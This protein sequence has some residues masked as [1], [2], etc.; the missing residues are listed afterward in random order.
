MMMVMMMMMMM[1]MVRF[2]PPPSHLWVVIDSI[3]LSLFANS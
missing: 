1:M 2:Q 3:A